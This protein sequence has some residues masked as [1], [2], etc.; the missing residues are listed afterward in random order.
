M[1]RA[2]GI[3]V[4]G[5]GLCLFGLAACKSE[6]KRFTTNVEVMQVRQ[7]GK[8]TKRTD[9]ELRFSDCPGDVRK[10]IR[11]D[12]SFAKC[13]EKLRAGEKLPADV[14]YAYDAEREGWRDEIVHLGDC[15]VK[16]DP[17][18]AANYNRVENCSELK[19]SGGVV[20]VHC[21]LTRSK[22]LVAACPW[23]DRN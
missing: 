10:I 9:L 21:D 20:G 3:F 2:L 16:T 7:F 18:D 15:D 12:E 23:L 17:K 4:L 11:T 8:T 14:S 13:G 22:E 19:L 1:R 5:A 6:P